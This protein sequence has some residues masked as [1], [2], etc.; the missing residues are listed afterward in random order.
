MPCLHRALPGGA[1]AHGNQ[2]RLLTAVSLLRRG[3]RPRAKVC[4]RDLETARSSDSLELGSPAAECRGRGEQR[5]N[6]NF[7]RG[8]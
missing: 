4:G 6:S 5:V 1:A 3:Y 8:L 7:L 2:V